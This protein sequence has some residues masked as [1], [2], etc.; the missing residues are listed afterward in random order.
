MSAR[1]SVR[2]WD[3]PDH[4]IIGFSEEP[5]NLIGFYRKP[6]SNM[7]A[8]TEIL[9]DSGQTLVPG[10]TVAYLGGPKSSAGFDILYPVAP[11]VFRYEGVFRSLSGQAQVLWAAV[12]ETTGETSKMAHPDYESLYFTHALGDPVPGGGHVLAYT[13]RA[14]AG[15]IIQTDE[16]YPAHEG[17]P[18]LIRKK[19]EGG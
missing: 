5:Y 12:N 4:E 18:D 17:I 3:S 8:K 1:R 9:L 10:D 7:I 2:V 16:W 13:N 14:G 6:V 11:V 15:R 19:F